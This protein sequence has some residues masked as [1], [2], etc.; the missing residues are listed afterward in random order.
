VATAP[1]AGPAGG[2]IAPD[3]RDYKGT[4]Q[5]QSLSQLLV[6]GCVL[7]LSRQQDRRGA[8]IVRCP[9]AALG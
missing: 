4:V 3:G 7:M 1:R 8:N 9:P 2:C 6:E 5:L